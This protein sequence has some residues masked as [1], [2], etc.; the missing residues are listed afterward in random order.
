ML[1]YSQDVCSPTLK[2]DFNALSE[3]G[4]LLIRLQTDFWNALYFSGMY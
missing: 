3:S 1:F 2:P 4:G